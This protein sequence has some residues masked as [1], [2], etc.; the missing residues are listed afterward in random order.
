MERFTMIML[1]IIFVAF[2]AMIVI[3]C[4]TSIIYMVGHVF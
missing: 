3:F 4:V 2:T 1:Y